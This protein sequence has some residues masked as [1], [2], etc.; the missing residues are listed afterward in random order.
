MQIFL[1]KIQNLL[2]NDHIMCLLDYFL[3]VVDLLSSQNLESDKYLFSQKYIQ[4]HF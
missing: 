1:Q 4:R 2:I 3:F